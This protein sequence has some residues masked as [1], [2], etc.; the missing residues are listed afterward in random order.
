MFDTIAGWIAIGIEAVGIAIARDG[1]LIR[2]ALGFA[3]EV[4][5]NGHWPW[6]HAGRSAQREER[7]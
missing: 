5:I 2:P 1:V 3:L 7:V 6:Q 4:E